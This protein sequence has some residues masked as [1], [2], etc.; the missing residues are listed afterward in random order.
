MYRQ[1]V[2][3]SHCKVTKCACLPG[4]GSMEEFE[5]RWT[6]EGKRKKV[7]QGIDKPRARPSDLACCLIVALSCCSSFSTCIV[8]N[9]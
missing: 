6:M 5:R 7:R 9:F 1:W 2:T 8:S 3:S 4:G